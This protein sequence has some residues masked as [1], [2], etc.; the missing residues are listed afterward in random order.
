MVIDN[1][2]S[3]TIEITDDGTA[4][5]CH[6]ILGEHYH[7]MRGALSES[8]HIYIE[9]GFNYLSNRDSLSILEMGFG[10]GLNCYLTLLEAKKQGISTRYTA[11]ELYPI[12]LDSAMGLGYGEDDSFISIHRAE[13]DKWH[14]INGNFKLLKRCEDFQSVTL[15]ENYDIVYF[16]AFAPDCQPNLWSEEIFTKIFRAMN[17]QG[18]LVTY[19][20]KGDVKRA[21]RQAG[22]TIERLE[23]ALGKHH[24]IRA[25]K[26]I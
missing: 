7:S 8:N 9:R 20:A 13:W 1:C 17:N 11:V 5:M 3:P 26:T 2:I 15:S 4:T 24:M 10:S 23:G 22:F 16:D 25:T 19:S 21:L 18:I 14:T 12:S 6:P